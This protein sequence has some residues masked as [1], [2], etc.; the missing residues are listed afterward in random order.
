MYKNL[1]IT[2]LT[3][4]SSLSVFAKQQEVTLFASIENGVNTHRPTMLENN[5][6]N[7][8]VDTLFTTLPNNN[9]KL[10]IKYG[11]VYKN[12]LDS[13]QKTVP[14]SYNNSVQDFIDLY[15]N[16]RK[17]LIGRMIG[18]SKYYFPFFEQSFRE[19][20]VP[21]EIKY[22]SIVES[23][24]NPNAV[25][26]VGAT[27]LW[28]F[29][30]A[31]AKIY[32][33]DMNN[34]IDERRDPLSASRAAAAYLR[35]AYDEFGDW[36][37]AIAAYNCGKGNVQ[38]AIK[39]AKSNNFWVISRYLP[40]ETKNYVPAYIAMAYVMNYHK[41]HNIETIS[42][43]IPVKNDIL[44]VNQPTSLVDLAR[45]LNIPLKQIQILNPIYKK[46]VAYG[47]DEEPCKIII[48]IP[49]KE[50]YTAIYDAL[51]NPIPENKLR[52]I[53]SLPSRNEK[54]IKQSKSYTHKVKRGE[55]V[56]AI[57]RKYGVEVQDIKA[58]NNFENTGKILP[59]MKINVQ[60]IDEHQ[61]VIK[62]S[63]SN[64]IYHVVKKGE[65]LSNIV[66]RFSGSS[67]KGIKTANR[68]RNS[69][70]QAGILL[71]IPRS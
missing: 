11:N 40:G 9:D 39:K 22:L 51:E 61:Y 44:Y 27:G 35:D 71:K 64:Y 47:S 50:S 23:A 69:K 52:K 33:L 63:E 48:P 16:K 31:T 46:Y 55:S 28:Q 53:A 3:I 14:L 20:S 15:V 6:A 70:V 29:M 21:E 30:F 67:I 2:I 5:N 1:L 58:W 49:S 43:S 19:Q 12:R 59:G 4:T 56:Y 37:L 8:I 32:G 7:I 34:F 68:L 41:K 18:L 10:P 26:R 45:A 36:L 65:T 57:A 38:K 42:P 54:T 17:T 66:D 60:S 24:L 62:Q 25:S 13:I